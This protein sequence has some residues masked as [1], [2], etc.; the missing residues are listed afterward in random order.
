MFRGLVLS[1]ENDRFEAKVCELNEASLPLADVHLRIS[2]STL[3]YKDALAITNRSPIVRA[4]PLVAGIDGVGVVE[5]TGTARYP[6]G[7]K[8]IH[9]GWGVGE[10]WWGCLAEKAA[11]KSEWLVPLP[12]GLSAR[13][14][15]GIGTAGLT[16][17]LCAQALQQQGV[18]A[19][20]GPVLVTGAAG[21]VGS[22]ATLILAGWGYKVVASTGRVQESDYL[23]SL[24]ATDVIERST[25]SAPGKPLQ[26]ER[27]AGVIDSVG[28]HTL[29]NACA[30]TQ[31]GGV[32]VACGLAQGMDF[33]GSVAPFILRAVKLIGVDS[34]MA[35][36]EARTA[37]WNALA[38]TL[39]RQ[40]LDSIVRVIRLDEAIEAAPDILDGR[41]RGRL[42]V[43][44]SEEAI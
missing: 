27:W 37:A 7:T 3:N 2:H 31:Y 10:N 39:D 17:M 32:V 43:Q 18:R 36:I 5:E 35:P 26:K 13:H 44:V 4:W 9:T 21:G 25:L 11:L 42:V 22:V 15:M 12:D 6:V 41:V 20:D 14:A 40:K 8:V 24:G 19:N 29:A 1:K 23:R 16:A 30:S 33:P 38:S 34:V 28:S